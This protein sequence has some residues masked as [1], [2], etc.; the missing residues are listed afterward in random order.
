MFFGAVYTGLDTFETKGKTR[1]EIELKLFG[2][3]AHSYTEPNR[4]V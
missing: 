3:Q 2:I 1:E 4:S